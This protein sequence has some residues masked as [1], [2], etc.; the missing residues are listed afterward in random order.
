ME[1]AC[2]G[3]YVKATLKRDFPYTPFVFVHINY[4][5]LWQ[6]GMIYHLQSVQ[7]FFKKSQYHFGD[8]M[9]S[10]K[11]SISPNHSRVVERQRAHCTDT[12]ILSCR[13]VYASAFF[14][15]N[16]TE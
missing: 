5:Y 1:A 12:V 6:W 11:N 15:D 8:A 16:D 10:L 3:K 2:H 9:K 7:F 4:L 14:L 13:F